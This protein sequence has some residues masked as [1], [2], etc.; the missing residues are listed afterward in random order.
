MR[1]KIPRYKLL[2]DIEDCG[3]VTRCMAGLYTYEPNLNAEYQKIVDVFSKYE[4]LGH[5][6]GF[7]TCG[8]GVLN[9]K[10]SCMNIQKMHLKRVNLFDL[11]EWV[12][13]LEIQD[14]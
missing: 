9:Y 14:S 3:K 12:G 7:F 8:G 5:P 10:P 1:I 6:L 2:A 11:L 13:I 4:N